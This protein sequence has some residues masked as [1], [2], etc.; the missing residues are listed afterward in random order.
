MFS[1]E[2]FQ[3][4]GLVVLTSAGKTTFEEFQAVAPKFYADVEAHGIRKILLDSRRSEGWDSKK[5]ES[6]AFP[7]WIKG[8]SLFDRI[9]VVVHDGLR[10][11]TSHFR[12]FFQNAGSAVRVFPPSQYEVALEWLKQNGTTDGRTL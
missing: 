11:E 8:R 3:D 2:V 7:A 9:A 5:A 12:E 6:M 1:Y 10:D 4:D